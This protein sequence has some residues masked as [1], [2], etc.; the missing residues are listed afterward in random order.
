MV[1]VTTRVERERECRQSPEEAGG[2]D[3]DVGGLG[4]DGHVL[5]A[6]DRVEE[7]HLLEE[8]L[9]LNHTVGVLVTQHGRV[10]S[11]QVVALALLSS[12]SGTL[13]ESPTKKGYNDRNLSI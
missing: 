3:R 9:C 4:V 1:T 10:A 8:E 6:V 13:E 11:I 5:G 7:L 12:R 2:G